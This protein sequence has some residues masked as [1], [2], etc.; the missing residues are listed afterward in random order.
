M[1]T[2]LILTSVIFSLSFLTILKAQPSKEKVS[3]LDYEGLATVFQSQVVLL[4]D[5][6]YEARLY[7]EVKTGSLLDPMEI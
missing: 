7:R 4:K 2:K 6:T 3:T 1:E 5:Q